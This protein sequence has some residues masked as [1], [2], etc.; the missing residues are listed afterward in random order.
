MLESF[1]VKIVL[2]KFFWVNDHIFNLVFGFTWEW[3]ASGQKHVSDDTD[4]PN[5]NFFVVNLV[6]NNFWSHV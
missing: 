2:D 6:L 5:V 4:T 3:I 1:T